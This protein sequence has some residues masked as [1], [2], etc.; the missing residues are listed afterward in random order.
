M[1]R[2]FVGVDIS[3]DSFSAAGLDGEGKE[4][5]SGSYSMDSEGFCK[6][7]EIVTTHCPDL[8]KEILCKKSLQGKT[9]S[10]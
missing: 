3:K 2:V 10:V 8:Q 5:F 1:D 4:W 6:F 7:L 9:L